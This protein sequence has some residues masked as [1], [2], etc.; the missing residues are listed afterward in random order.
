MMKEAKAKKSLLPLH[1]IITI[2]LM[3]GF[4]YL[5]APEPVTAVGMQMLGIFLGLIYGWSFSSLLWPSLMGMAALLMTNCVP[6]KTFLTLSFANESVVFIIFIFIFTTAIDKEGVTGFLAN[7]CMSRKILQGHPWRMSLGLLL[8]AAVTGAL[9]NMFAAIFI[10]WGIFY[11]IC[12][13]A[14]IKPYEKYPT[15]MILGIAISSIIGSCLLPYRSGPIIVLGAYQSLTGNTVDF[16][17][18]MLF[19]VPLVLLTIL[20]YLIICRVIFRVDISKLENISLD[21]IDREGLKMTRRQ[22]AIMSFLALFILFAI[23]PT[24]LPQ[25]WLIVIALKRL[26]NIGILIVLLTIMLWLKIEDKPLIN[27]QELAAEGIIWDMVFLF[28][29]IFPLSGLLMGEETGIKLFMVNA[30]QPLFASVSPIVFMFG[31][32]LLPTLITNFAN[33]IVI[34]M[35]FLQIICAFAGTLGIN[36]VPLVMTLLICVNLAFYTPAA[37]APAAVVFGNTAWIRPKDIYTTGGLMIILLA[38][39]VIS[40]GIIWGN[41]IF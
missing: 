10:F 7:W 16:L 14:D 27:V 32:L 6:L 3:F 20:T 19:V 4:A 33:N 22:K 40:F 23:L 9:A 2:M 35:I 28:A 36:E 38:V 11:E 18:F 25:T 26:G 1:V 39:V 30:L 29:I 5:P 21:F 8:G 24:I 34:A 37:S 12:K 41:I 13:Q 17:P 31:V 15:L